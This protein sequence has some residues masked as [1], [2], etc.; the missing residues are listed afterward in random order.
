[1]R[2]TF[3]PIALALLAACTTAGASSS[4]LANSKWRF[5]LIDGEKPVAGGAKLEFAPNRVS[6]WVG[7]NGMGSDLKIKDGR[8]IVEGIVATMMYCDGLMDQ[9]HAVSEL[10]TAD[11][12]YRIENGR[13]FLKSTAHSAELVPAG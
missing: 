3:A 1:M 10:L 5:A 4:D 13:L 12:T 11:P 8:L 9:E 2:K 7:C 6:A